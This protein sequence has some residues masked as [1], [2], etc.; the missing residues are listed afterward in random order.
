[1][2]MGRKIFIIQHTASSHP[3]KLL[4]MLEKLGLSFEILK[5]YEH[6]QFKT[7]QYFDGVIILGG[8]M[9]V[10]DE[11]QF[12]WIKAECEFIRQ[13]VKKEI[14]LLGICLGAQ[15]I[16]KAHGAL[17]KKNDTPELGWSE[18][19][20]TEF[21]K[22]EKFYVIKK[23]LAAYQWHDET[24]EIPFGAI[25]LSFS[26]ACINQAYK[27]GKNCYGIQ[28]HPETH[29]D[30]IHDWLYKEDGEGDVNEVRARGHTQFVQTSEMHLELTRKL[31]ARQHEHLM[32]LLKIFE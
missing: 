21:A 14:P 31:Q 3:G 4:E 29:F 22:N 26:A 19:S 2:Q 16:A 17:V 24:F 8:G 15:M 12:S 5:L 13:V 6:P 32:Q 9:S 30:M 11:E 20:P 27:L 7:P 1:M 23:N 25:R 18:I 10:N 28:Y